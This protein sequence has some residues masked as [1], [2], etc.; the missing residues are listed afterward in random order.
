MHIVTDSGTDH[1]L[2]PQQAAE[3]NLHTVPL[4]VTLDGITYQEGVDIQ[5]A[6]FYE[7]LAESGNLPVTSQPSAGQFA[8]LYRRLAAEGRI[9]TD[10]WDLYDTRHAVYRPAKMTAQ[11]LE[12]GYWQAYRDFYRWGSIL[13]SAGVHQRLRDRARHFAY[14]A[15]W[16]RFEMVWDAAIRT[17]QVQLASPLLA[18][19][20]GP[21][22]V[23]IPGSARRR[24]PE[25][26]SEGR[27]S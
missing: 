5:P 18:S 3:Y 21:G 19:V 2:S 16:G 11:A 4:N 24:E 13:K 17:G 23:P 27:T 7:L 1:N 15:G 10:N 14:T 22:R 8:E 9:T 12:K 6:D 26:V 25:D 20:L